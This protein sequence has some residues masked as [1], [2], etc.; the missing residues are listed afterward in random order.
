MSYRDRALEIINERYQKCVEE[1]L[2]AWERLR[3]STAKGERRLFL[4]GCGVLGRSLYQMFIKDGYTIEGFVDNNEKNW[5]GEIEGVKCIS[6]KELLKIENAVVF[7]TIG[8]AYEVYAQLS[9]TSIEMIC[10]YPLAY[11]SIM[12][13]N[14]MRYTKEV[15]LENIQKLFDILEDEES[16]KIAFWK[17][18]SWFASF[19]ELNQMQFKEIYSE[20]IYMPKNIFQ[21][22]S[23]EKII[24]CGAYN[25]DTIQ[26][27]LENR[28]KWNKY[29]AFEMSEK[30]FNKLINYKKD[31]LKEIQYTLQVQ[32]V[33]VGEKNDIIYYLDNLSGTLI[34][35]EKIGKKANV[36]TLDSVI[37]DSISYIKMDIEGSELSAL[38]GGERLIKENRPKCAICVYHQPSDLWEIPLYLKELVPEYRIF[39]RHH[40][41]ITNDTVCYA[42]IQE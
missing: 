22:Q 40:G 30:N 18:K 33:G 9:K 23:K 25:G 26:Y 28:I 5:G 39:L 13:N 4:F 12:R 14:Y 36:V 32:N 10:Q 34:E 42:R 20:G 16:K 7:I 21:F 37:N 1:K 6:P 29:Y 41:Y 11:F 27:F 35:S 38:K 24:D 31:F 15:L 19:E 8:K 3:K 2:Y 17:I